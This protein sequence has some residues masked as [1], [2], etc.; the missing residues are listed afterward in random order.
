M[1]FYKF[2]NNLQSHVPLFKLLPSEVDLLSE[3][4]IDGFATQGHSNRGL[5]R[6]VTGYL[7]HY[8]LDGFSWDVI[9][10]EERERVKQL[11]VFFLFLEHWFVSDHGLHWF[12][13]SLNFDWSKKFAPLI[14]TYPDVHAANLSTNQ[15]WAKINNQSWLAHSCFPELAS[16]N[17][18]YFF[19]TFN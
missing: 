10:W 13:F 11:F 16:T 8:S 18:L 12:C 19:L 9:S 5:A 2:L 14:K 15:T 17:L 7:V 3:K 4:F 1:F 6:F